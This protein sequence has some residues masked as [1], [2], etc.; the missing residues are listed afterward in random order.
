MIFFIISDIHED[1]LSLEKVFKIINNE[2]DLFR[3]F[4]LGDNVGFS[5]HY[6]KNEYRRESNKCIDILRLNN[7]ISVLGNHDLNFLNLKPSIPFFEYSKNS[8]ELDSQIKYQQTSIW[9]YLDELKTFLNDENLTYL[10]EASNYIIENE[11]L[12]SH[13]LYPDIN[14]NLVIKNKLVNKILPVHFLFMEINNIKLSFVGHLHL[15]KPI[16]VT[17]NLEKIEMTENVD[18]KIDFEKTS[19]IIFCPPINSYKSNFSKFVS[20]NRKLKTLKYYTLDITD[21]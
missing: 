5:K 3:V 20:Y 17:S 11:V 16:I 9:L 21:A 14:G 10:R 19:F 2:K 13:F 6:L 7:V 18:F 8:K 4:S 15:D 12:F 1:Y